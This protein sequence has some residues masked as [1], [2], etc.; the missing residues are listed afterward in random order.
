MQPLDFVAYHR[1]ALERDEVKHNVMLA[2]LGRLAG[3][4]PPDLRLW[5]LGD[6]GACAAQTP[7]YPIVLG[8]VTSTQSRSLAE[9]TRD[10]DYPGVVGPDWT[11]Q[12]FAARAVELG[13]AFRE[14][15]PQQIHA[16]A[17]TPHY[18]GAPGDARTVE[19]ADAALFADWMIAFMREAVPHDPPPNRER[20]EQTAG[21]GRYQ[22]WIVDGEPVSMAGIVRR[23]RHAAAIAGVYTPPAL[24]GRGYAGSVVAAV[25]ER[26]FAEGKTAACL[27]TDLRNPFS[28]RC[29]AKIGFRPVCDSW[30]YPKV[31]SVG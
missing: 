20:L 8:E 15:I 30:H 10:L 23:T 13:V 11:A 12:W 2:N 16:L 9:E 4:H 31:R 28:N 1:P 3:E 19:V 22:F 21:E 17:S 26:V 14:P 25:V 27:Y 29:Y 6:P 18:P 5:T 7:G 24:R